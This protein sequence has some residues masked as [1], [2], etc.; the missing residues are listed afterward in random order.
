MMSDEEFLGYVDIHSR[1]DL[2]L[3]STDDIIRLHKLAN[4]DPPGGLWPKAFFTM[5]HEY[6][7]PRIEKARARLK[8]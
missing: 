2:A 7:K 5:R 4:E 1:T 8:P 3:F 6:V